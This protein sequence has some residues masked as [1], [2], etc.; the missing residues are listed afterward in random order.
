MAE[1]VSDAVQEQSKGQPIS[2]YVNQNFVKALEE[3][4]FSKNASEKAL[5]MTMSQ[6]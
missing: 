1:A 5:F 4:G 2:T 3:M 6:G